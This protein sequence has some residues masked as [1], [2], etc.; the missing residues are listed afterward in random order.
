MGEFLSRR[1]L[2]LGGSFPAGGGESSWCMAVREG[3]FPRGEFLLFR[4]LTAMEREGT[5][6]SFALPEGG[7]MARLGDRCEGSLSGRSSPSAFSPLSGGGKDCG[8]W[9]CAGLFPHG[10][11]SNTRP[12]GL[13][14]E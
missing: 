3:P 2:L 9:P 10:A 8:A 1:S 13:L 11:L 4:R 5:V 7:E 6:G 14:R 12:F